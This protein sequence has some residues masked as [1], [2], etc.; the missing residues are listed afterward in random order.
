[1]GPKCS[2]WHQN[3]LFEEIMQS[4]ITKNLVARYVEPIYR[5]EY[6]ICLYNCQ[7]YF[8]EIK[9]AKTGRASSFLDQNR[10]LCKTLVGFLLRWVP[11]MTK[12]NVHRFVFWVPVVFCYLN[13]M[14]IG[15]VAL[16][17][18]KCFFVLF[19]KS[20][21]QFST[22][23]L[24]FQFILFFHSQPHLNLHEKDQQWHPITMELI[25]NGPNH[26]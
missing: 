7:S 8:W 22:Q 4:C 3:R 18:C 15:F 11:K 1:M 20:W 21:I 12:N 9:S 13:Y 19:F 24:V 25:G 14:L 16:K 2:F 17:F 26:S 10:Q 6:S 23:T 5:H